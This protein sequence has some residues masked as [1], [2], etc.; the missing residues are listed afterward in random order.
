MRVHLHKKKQKVS[1]GNRRNHKRRK[2]T[3][4]TLHLFAV[5]IISHGGASQGLA[6]QQPNKEVRVC[7]VLPPGLALVPHCDLKAVEPRGGCRYLLLFY[8]LVTCPYNQLQHV[9]PK[10]TLPTPADNNF[11]LMIFPVAIFGGCRPLTASQ[12][13]VDY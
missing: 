9:Q 7:V 13:I 6:T 10:L 12:I 8:F 5:I 1:R 3:G 2:E 4:K 11:L